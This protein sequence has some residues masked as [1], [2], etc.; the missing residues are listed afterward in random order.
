MYLNIA[1]FPKQSRRFIDFVSKKSSEN[2]DFV[3]FHEYPIKPDSFM[4][5]IW[6]LDW[7]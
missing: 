3:T 1:L 2:P 7:L 4:F 6:I 5:K